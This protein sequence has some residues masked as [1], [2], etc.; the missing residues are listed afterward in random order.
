MPDPL[1]A[2]LFD[3]DG[4]LLDPIDDG[5]P[6]FK[7]R[8]GIPRTQLV[9]PN[10]PRLPREATDEFI[11]LEAG[12]ADRSV[13]RPG[14]KDLLRDLE[15]H[16]VRVALVT[17]NSL[18]SANT[19]L[20]R[21]EMPFPVVKTRADGPMKPAPDLVL[22][23]LADVDARPEDAVFVGDTGADVG[24]ARA[25]GL[26]GCVLMAEPWNEVFEGDGVRRVTGVAALRDAL[27]AAGAPGEIAAVNAA[28]Q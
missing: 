16:G 26:R 4:T 1:R 27:V 18:E 13:P 12:V 5:L 28:A 9:V 20:T 17:N 21:H 2:V 7:D 19:V 23:A 15:R 10:L 11:A 25:A 24:A 6:A 8:W 3:M 14:I 22:A